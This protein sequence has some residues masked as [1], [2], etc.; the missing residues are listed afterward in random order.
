MPAACP[1]YGR[2]DS[3]D[4]PHNTAHDV[5]GIE[6]P[7]APVV[8]QPVITLIVVSLQN[9]AH[10]QGCTCSSTFVERKQPR[11]LPEK[12]LVC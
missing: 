1:E 3:Q 9:T 4:A 10:Q 2:Y 11:I 8:Q 5:A 7:L 12:S 6:P